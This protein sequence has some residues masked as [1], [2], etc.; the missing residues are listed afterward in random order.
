MLVSTLETYQIFRGHH[1]DFSWF[2]NCKLNL[3]R[4]IIVDFN[5][6]LKKRPHGNAGK[7]RFRRSWKRI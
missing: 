6:V 5:Q 3:V 4:K 2:K 7:Y 1:I